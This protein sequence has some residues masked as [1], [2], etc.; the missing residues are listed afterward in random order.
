M[1][2]L[3]KETPSHTHK[4]KDII[5][6]ATEGITDPTLYQFNSGPSK[7]RERRIQRKKKRKKNENVRSLAAGLSKMEK[8]KER[9]CFSFAK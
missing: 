2:S 4:K 5:L 6:K 1:R 3:S 9:V 7:Q 8:R